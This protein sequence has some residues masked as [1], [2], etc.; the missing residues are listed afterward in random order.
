MPKKLLRKMVGAKKD[1]KME[2]NSEGVEAKV[3][4]MDAKQNE[5]KEL[6]IDAKEKKIQER[7]EIYCQSWKGR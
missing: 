7:E 6:V 5:S 3:L 1:T 2:R 4:Q